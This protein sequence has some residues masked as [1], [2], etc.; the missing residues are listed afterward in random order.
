MNNWTEEKLLELFAQAFQEAV[1]PALE[2]LS[3]GVNDLESDMDSRFDS[4]DEE[5]LKIND[6]LDRHAKYY[7][8]H[9]KRII[10]LE[11]KVGLS[12]NRNR[13]LL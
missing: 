1:L 10:K 4:V 3:K 6:K 5:L 11:T 9:E 13:P 7:D 8:D 12:P 2:D